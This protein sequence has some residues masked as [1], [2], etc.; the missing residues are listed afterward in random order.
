MLS[1]VFG[2]MHDYISTQLAKNYTAEEAEFHT[3]ILS[4]RDRFNPLEYGQD[5]HLV[6]CNFAQSSLFLAQLNSY[7]LPYEKMG[8]LRRTHK[9][10]ATDIEEYTKAQKLP[11]IPLN[12][13][14]VL[15]SLMTAF[16][17]ANLEHPIV[18]MIIVQ[19][20]SYVDY[21]ISEMGRSPY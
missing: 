19:H 7:K 17:R 15:A 4:L 21:S 20:F 1:F 16:L 9:Q 11:R 13:D 18:N 3:T 8:C 5:K 14:I 2:D 6:H 12:E 10:I